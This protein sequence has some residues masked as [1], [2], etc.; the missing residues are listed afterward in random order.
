M[1]SRNDSCESCLACCCWTRNGEC[2]TR[3][4]TEFEVR[5]A[6]DVVADDKLTMSFEGHGISSK[7][8]LDETVWCNQRAIWCHTAN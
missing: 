1:H 2:T 7:S 3:V 6:A 5:V 4:G 8:I